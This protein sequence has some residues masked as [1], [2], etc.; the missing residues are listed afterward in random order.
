MYAPNSLLNLPY[1]FQEKNANKLRGG[2]SLVGG[3]LAHCLGVKVRVGIGVVD[4]DAHSGGRAVTGDAFPQWEGN[5]C[6]SIEEKQFLALADGSGV[7]R[8]AFTECCRRRGRR[9]VVM[10]Q[11]LARK[12]CDGEFREKTLRA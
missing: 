4:D 8:E 6:A 10:Y 7:G 12:E 2:R 3:K 1:I 9:S 11:V 5:A